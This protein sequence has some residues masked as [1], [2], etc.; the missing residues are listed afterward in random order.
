MRNHKLETLLVT[1]IVG[2]SLGSSI[3]C[4]P[5]TAA[6]ANRD[7]T[8]V[9]ASAGA[10]A[11]QAEVAYNNKTIDQTTTNRTVINDLGNGYEQ[12]RIAFQAYLNAEAAY[13]I[14]EN[15]QIGA[16]SPNGGSASTCQTATA[17]VNTANAQ[18]QQA[19]T[20]LNEAV[21]ALSTKTKQVQSLK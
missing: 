1:L 11:A 17:Q 21:S 15:L 6:T 9:I 12:A 16:C 5:K 2:I 3:G 19:S 4:A 10:A 20:K 14:S 13:Q 18:V 8:M 7:I